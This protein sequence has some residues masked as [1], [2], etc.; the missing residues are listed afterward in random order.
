MNRG[1]ELLGRCTLLECGDRACDS[2]LTAG[3]NCV[4][5]GKLVREID[6]ALVHHL[7]D[8]ADEAKT[9]AIFGGEDADAAAGK[10]G[11]LFGNDD[12]AATS[13][14]LHVMGALGIE[15]FAQVAEVLDVATLVRGDRHALDVFLDDRAH[16]LVDAAVMTEVDD[17]R[18][19][20]LQ[21][22]AHDV[23]RGVVAIEEGGRRHESDGVLRA[24]FVTHACSIQLPTSTYCG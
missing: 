13:V 11:D 17:L 18:A 19:L 4:E 8:H 2:G 3:E 22:A 9:L 6:I 15:E 23:D 16:D 10:S 24:C 14:D 20:R 5:G 12:A 7:G 1:A 21:D